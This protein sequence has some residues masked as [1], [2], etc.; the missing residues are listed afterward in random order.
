[1]NKSIVVVIG[2]IFSSGAY[3]QVNYEIIPS[4]S[5][6]SF[7]TIKNQY[8]IESALMKPTKG[9]IK[10]DGFFSIEIPVDSV[11][12]GIPIRDER[13]KDLFFELANYP[14]VSVSGKLDL[15]L[16]SNEPKLLSLPV[17]VEVY[18]NM[19]PFVFP[20]VVIK[21]NNSILVSSYG[22]I[23]ISASDF[24]IPSA[25]LVKLAATVG[26]IKISEQVPVS[27][28]LSFSK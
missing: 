7:S 19:K 22:Q 9:L 10:Q 25:N 28:T 27:F 16:I 24:G 8:I 1:M 18:G 2:C 3:A 15:K 11:S 4:S 14:Q 26:G 6:L 20:V 5:S 17:N 13:L 12:T 23:V 21:S